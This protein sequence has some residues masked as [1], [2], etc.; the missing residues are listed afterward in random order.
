M[1]AALSSIALA[2]L[3]VPAT[4]ADTVIDFRNQGKDLQF[5]TDGKTARINTRG[6]DDYMLVKFEQNTIFSVNPEQNQVTNISDALPAI[7]F[8][9]PPEIKLTLKPLGKGPA[10]AGYATTRYRLTAN[11]E[12][13]GSLYASREALEGSAIEEMFD[14]LKTMADNHLQSL[15]GFAAL[16]PTCQL[17]QIELAGKLEE[18]GAPMRMTSKD[19]S[20]DSEITKILKD[21]QVKTALLALP[22]PSQL[23]S[24][25][26]KVSTSVKQSRQEQHAPEHQSE[27]QRSWRPMPPYGRVPPEAM[28]DRWRYP[29]V[30]R[31]R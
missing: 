6:S 24:T 25:D 3:F 8:S 29:V 19:G 27:P 15:G 22:A 1:K 21:V 23:A 4:N 28:V 18:V 12:Y 5:L 10:V 26:K 14:T 20:I 16:I 30:M 9:Q 13:C 17:A 11:G 2:F 31:H 7:G